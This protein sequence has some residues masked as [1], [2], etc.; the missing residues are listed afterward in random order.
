MK[1]TIPNDIDNE[2]RAAYRCGRAL[3]REK[4]APRRRLKRVPK[5]LRRGVKP[6]GSPVIVISMD[7]PR[8]GVESLLQVGGPLTVGHLRGELAEARDS[9]RRVGLERATLNVVAQREKPL[10]LRE[11]F[12][13][14]RV[15]DPKVGEVEE[16]IGHARGVNLGRG[17]QLRGCGLVPHHAPL[18][19][20]EEGEVHG[21]E[22]GAVAASRGRHLGHAPSLAASSC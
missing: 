4:D 14:V 9:G 22:L 20:Q 19:E 6:V 1:H 2:R 10:G 13:D 15:R 8:A 18:V 21:G 5:P 11:G 3:H 16:A 12:V 7:L 17:V